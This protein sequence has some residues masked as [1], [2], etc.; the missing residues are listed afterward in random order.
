MMGEHALKP[1]DNRLGWVVKD[2]KLA[3]I[4]GTKRKA[5]SFVSSGF[6]KKEP[7]DLKNIRNSE[8]DAKLNTSDVDL[9][10]KIV[11]GREEES[12]QSGEELPSGNLKLQQCGACGAMYHIDDAS[13][14]QHNLSI[15]HQL[16]LPHSDP[17]S[18]IDRKNKGFEYMSA[19]G[20]DPDAKKGLGAEGEGILRP[21]KAIKKEDKFGVGAGELMKPEP[22]L[23]KKVKNPLTK[24]E[25]KAAEYKKQ[26][27]TQK[28]QDLF[29]GNDKVNEYF[30][31]RP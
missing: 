6:T 20:W 19:Y 11:F 13:K 24:G 7:V 21:I 16:A 15:G 17:P 28:M 31:I 27:K 30:D 4:P 9:Y 10:R 3:E 23:A 14:A 25:I 22:A 8:N 26:K 29:Y 12:T 5:I 2:Q 18:A 1:D